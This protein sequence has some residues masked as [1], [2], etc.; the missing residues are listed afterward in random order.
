M[1]GMKHA[2]CMPD[3]DNSILGI[4]SSILRHFGIKPHHKT[5]PDL[6]SLLA[7]RP[8][9]NI[10]MMIFDG[11]GSR[12]IS[13]NLPP[14]SFL[15]KHKIRDIKS[16]FPSTTT[17]ATTSL[18]SGLSP[19]EHGWLGWQLYFKESENFIRL[20]MS[21]DFY[22]GAPVD[23]YFKKHLGYAPI[24]D[25]VAKKHTAVNVHEICPEHYNSASGMGGA[26]TTR[27][28]IGDI[29]KLGDLFSRMREI[30]NSRGNNFVVAYWMDPDMQAHDTG[31]TSAPVKSIME[32]ID[33][34]LAEL[35]SEVKDTLII[36]T[37]DHGHIDLSDDI[38]LDD[39]P[40]IMD[41]LEMPFQM[42]Y[43]AASFHVKPGCAAE[44]KEEF[45][46]EFGEWFMLVTR[47]DYLEKFIGPGVPHQ[48]AGDFI[49]D[50]VAIAISDRMFRHTAELTRNGKFASYH[51]G[52]TE[53]EMLVPLIVIET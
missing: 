10:I 41:Y 16:V 17:A 19:K 42:E 3:Y 37:A 40:R 43:R 15:C 51:A 4:P 18:Y 48:R 34:G 30:C 27:T 36:V 32:E 9:K 12:L 5:L 20:Y 8:Y 11:M 6:D 38:V 50:F 21:D 25:L 45:E 44:F 49:G 13:D 7:A 1:F 52:L 47:D 22:T 31:T 35:K 53:S 39:Y 46:K 23:S 2:L 26:D 33:K 24:A 28:K 14:D 29:K